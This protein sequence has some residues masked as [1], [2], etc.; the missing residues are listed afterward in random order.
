MQMMESTIS[1]DSFL[2]M[3]MFLRTEYEQELNLFLE[4]QDVL[5]EMVWWNSFAFSITQQ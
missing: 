5:D 1:W 2:M 3:I 4:F